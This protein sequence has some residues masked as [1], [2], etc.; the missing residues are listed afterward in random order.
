LPLAILPT[1]LYYYLM[2]TIRDQVRALRKRLGLSTAA[3]AVRLGEM[4]AP[5][6]WRTVESWEEGRRCPRPEA[7]EALKTLGMGAKDGATHDR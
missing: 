1:S 7:M 5:V 6:S 4:G 2:D 3:L